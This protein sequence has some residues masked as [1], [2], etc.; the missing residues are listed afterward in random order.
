MK[1]ILHTLALTSI[2]LLGSTVLAHQTVPNNIEITP[3]SAS[4][5][6]PF[7]IYEAAIVGI[8]NN[9]K[10]LPSL[11]YWGVYDVAW[12]DPSSKNDAVDKLAT[13]NADECKI[14]EL[15]C[16]MS[17]LKNREQV[18][19]VT[20]TFAES[21][22][23]RAERLVAYQSIKK[24]LLS[25]YGVPS[26]SANDEELVRGEDAFVQGLDSKY[27]LIWNGLG[28]NLRLLLTTNELLVTL[29]PASSQANKDRVQAWRKFETMRPNLSPQHPLNQLLDRQD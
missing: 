6:L 11:D 3:G 18:S 26:I 28:S 13:Q 27:E 12:G 2:L 15:K 7:E 23:G 10:L 25:A 5:E 14:A 29:K 16:S 1:F 8:N 19:G 20:Y 17:V 21:I 22:I 9:R 4:T 24:S